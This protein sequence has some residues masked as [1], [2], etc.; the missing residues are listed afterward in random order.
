VLHTVMAVEEAGGG[1]PRAHG[2][3]V[4]SHI[5]IFSPAMKEKKKKCGYHHNELAN[6]SND[7]FFA[8]LVN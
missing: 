1:G 4:F 8:N 2:N 6:P 7:K 3:S 5:Q